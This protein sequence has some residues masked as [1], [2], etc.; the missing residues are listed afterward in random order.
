M[1]GSKQIICPHCQVKGKVVTLVER[2]SNRVSKGKMAL[3]LLTGGGSLG[4]T[5]ARK[6]SNYVTMAKCK[7]CKVKWQLN[8]LGR[9]F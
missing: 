4:F 5:G 3:G 7:N 1:A 2:A 6:K 8:D 9:I